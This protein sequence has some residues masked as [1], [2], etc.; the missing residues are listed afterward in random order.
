M[1]SFPFYKQ[2]DT[3]DCGPTCLRMITK[4]YG[5]NYSLQS[6][7]EK[8]G[9]NKEGVSLASMG[10]AAES[11][12]FR[13]LV[14]K[15]GFDKLAADA[16]LPF[17]AHWKQNHFVIVFE[18]KKDKVSVADPQIG[19]I[20]LTKKEFISSWASDLQDDEPVGV[21][22]LFE[23]TP[24]FYANEDEKHESTLNFA[25]I[26]TYLFAFKKLLF[27]LFLGLMMGS[28]LQ[29]L[30][31]FLTQSVID[32]GINNRNLNFV[33]LVLIGQLVLYA[34]RSVIEFIRSW[35]LLHIG[36]R[37]NI[38]ILSDFFVKL[39]RL[40]MSY[41][42]TKFQG[43]LLQRI[44]D[45]DKIESFLTYSV[46]STLFSIINFFLLGAVLIF[47]DLKLF[48]L[49][50][51]G[52][53]IY[54]FWIYI[55]LGRRRILNIKR[56]EVSA[57][58]QSSILQIIDGIQD[59]KL[60]NSEQQKRWEW[61]NIQARLFRLNMQ[62]LGL[63]QIQGA[64]ALFINEGKNIFM[65]YMAAKGVIDGQMTLGMMLS[66][67][68]ILGQL[69]SP[70][71]QLIAFVQDYQDAKLSLERLNDIHKVNDEEP[72]NKQSLIQL[73]EN[74][75][76][77]LFNTTFSYPGTT[78]P[79]LNSIYLE[80]PYGKVTAIVGTSGS[81]KTTILKLLLK[82]YQPTMG[83]IIIGTLSLNAINHH[84]WR[85]KCG[86][87]MQDGFIFSDTI[88]R[89]IAV[90]EDDIDFNKL[91]HAVR[92]A[93]IA[94]YIETLPL[95]Y[96]TK[97]GAEGNGLS[98]GQKQR[99]LIARAVYKEPEF[100]FFDEATNALDANNEK[101]IMKNLEEFFQGRTVIIVAHRLSTVKNAHQ[102]VVVDKGVVT[103]R[104][105]HE[106]LT[107]LRGSYYNL[108]KN[109]LELGS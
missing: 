103:E 78:K 53:A 43:D 81:G 38:M 89:N 87:V 107:S 46:I 11:L 47:F 31:P 37:I 35:I 75:N 30:L 50:L 90:G 62:S 72:D 86:V 102:I 57:K 65:T 97:I 32:I 76:L 28:V 95:G 24:K 6:L 23:T 80:I 55:F 41:F 29:L 25:K 108:V 82:S 91:Y 45:H 20:S 77:Y 10:V 39:L 68:Y 88:A 18:I 14:A 58:S 27:Q 105:N 84:Y 61:E 96:N 36:S 83:Q 67:Q 94:E 44:G 54:V 22:M 100:M 63:K 98:Q 64:G 85:S 1:K 104:G 42:D 12:G 9:I 34:G 33:N 48:L 70:I 51:A 26:F 79:V 8:C 15:V 21:A 7:R 17:I 106:Y 69:N 71:E 93:N 49:F 56:F 40:P 109:Q 99:I 52:S 2:L 5:K 73:P 16:P 66:V 13:T 4:H 101:I 19:L 92:V 59:I 60:N 74:K 3:M